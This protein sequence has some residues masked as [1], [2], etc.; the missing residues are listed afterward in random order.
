MGAI[1]KGESPFGDGELETLDGLPDGF[2][3]PV[4]PERPE[5][6]SPGLDALLKAKAAALPSVKDTVA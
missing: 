2:D 4:L 6:F 5:E 1:F 3:M